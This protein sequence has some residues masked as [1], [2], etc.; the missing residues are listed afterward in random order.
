MPVFQ[1]R[2]EGF[3]PELDGWPVTESGLEAGLWVFI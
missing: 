1:M 3:H 2:T